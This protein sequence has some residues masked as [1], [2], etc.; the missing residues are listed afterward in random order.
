MASLID[1]LKAVLMVQLFYAFCITLLVY[2]LPTASLD[3]ITQFREPC[4]A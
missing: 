3:D 4:C 2:A 1:Y